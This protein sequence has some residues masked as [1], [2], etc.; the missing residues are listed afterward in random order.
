MKKT[1]VTTAIIFGVG[2]VLLPVAFK[3]LLLGFHSTSD[4]SND[5]RLW[6]GY[7]HHKEYVL[8][9]DLFLMKVSGGM[10]QSGRLALVP[11]RSDKK[12]GGYYDSPETIIAYEA[13][14]KNAAIIDLGD[15]ASYRI[16]VVGILR[17]G[18]RLR[19]LRLDRHDGWSLWTSG[20]TTTLTPW[21]EV[22][23]GEYVGKEVDLTDVSDFTTLPKVDDIF[24]YEPEKLLIEEAGQ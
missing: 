11:A 10:A 22:L 1:I 21:A 16:D 4:A 23:D 17:K 24:V 19:A 20:S 14:P 9:K 18:T 5:S 7:Q 6:G 2:L 15:G 3:V 13:D 12:R 8:I